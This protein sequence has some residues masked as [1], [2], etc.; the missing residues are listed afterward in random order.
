[1]RRVDAAVDDARDLRERDRLARLAGRVEFRGVSFAYGNGPPVLHDVSFT[2][3]QGETLA[4]L[5]RNGT[6]TQFVREWTGWTLPTIYGPP[7]VILALALSVA[8]WLRDPDRCCAD[9]APHRSRH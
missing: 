7:G 9:P 2:L 3:G 1:M 8:E 6:I 5:G 4:L